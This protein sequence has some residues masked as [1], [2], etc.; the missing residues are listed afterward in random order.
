[1]ILIQCY[2]LVSVSPVPCYLKSNKLF[3]TRSN[4]YCSPKQDLNLAPKCL[5]LLEFETWGLIPLGHRLPHTLTLLRKNT[6]YYAIAMSKKL[7]CFK[8]LV[9][10]VSHSNREIFITK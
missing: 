3:L 8:N 10:M 5:F 9:K 2:Y 6:L 7:A 4:Q 1:M